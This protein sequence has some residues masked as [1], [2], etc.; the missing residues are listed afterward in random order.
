MQIAKLLLVTAV[1]A[2]T[3]GAMA[4]PRPWYLWKLK[5]D[6]IATDTTTCAQSMTGTWMQVSGPFK[7]NRCETPGLPD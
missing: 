2:L 5:L 6:G 7:D 3:T 4:A 1:A